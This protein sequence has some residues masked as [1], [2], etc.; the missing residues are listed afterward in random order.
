MKGVRIHAIVR[1][2]NN[3]NIDVINYTEDAI[4]YIQRALA[5]AKLKQIEINEEEQKCTVIADSDQVSLIVGRN[6]VNIR[7]AMKLTGYDI[8]V[9]R[10][11][12]PFEEYEDDIELIDLKDELGSEIV[13]LLINNRHD[14]AVEVLTAGVPELEKIDGITKEKAEEIIEIIKNQFEEEEEG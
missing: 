7:L 1:E 6:G 4:V 3:E 12:K 11:E 10:E 2:L 5:P 8:E 13:D 14:T 9:I